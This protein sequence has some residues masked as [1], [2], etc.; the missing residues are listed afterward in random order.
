MTVFS[1]LADHIPVRKELKLRVENNIGIVCNVHDFRVGYLN[2]TA[3][4]VFQLIDGQRTVADIIQ[5][6]L[7]KVD[8]DRNIFEKDLVEL[9][10]N[11]QWQKLITL[12]R[13]M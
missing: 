13:K 12:K 6:F 4:I 2:E 7:E 10:R 11:F 1:Y 9:L 8:V 3:L 5:C